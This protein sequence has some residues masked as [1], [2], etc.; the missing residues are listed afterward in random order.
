MPAALPIP[1]AL[2]AERRALARMFIELTLAFHATIFS[3]DQTP[4]CEP[5][6]NLALVAV[7][8]MLGHAEG[9]PMTA[10]QIA[11]YVHMPALRSCAG[12]MR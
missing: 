5:D 8:V 9:Y 7:A 2:S 1:L 4:P 6:A 12:S 11:S 3:L 10:S